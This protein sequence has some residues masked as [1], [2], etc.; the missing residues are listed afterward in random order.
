[1][2]LRGAGDLLGAEQSG[3]VAGVGFEMFC[4]ML[5]EATHELRGETV[6]HDVEPELSFDVEALLAGRA[7]WPKSACGSRSTSASRAP[8]RGRGDE[9]AQETRESLR[10]AAARS[11]ALRRAHAA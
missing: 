8:R 6:A 4:R 5:E 7:T 11:Q 1:M 2:E 9:L 3:F 10:P